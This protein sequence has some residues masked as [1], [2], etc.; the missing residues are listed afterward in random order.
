MKKILLSII[1]LSLTTIINAQCYESLN[2]GGAHT[3]GKTTNGFLWGWGYGLA[4]Q[5][6]TFNETEPNP[7]QEIGRA[8]V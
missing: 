8:H 6:L 7:I 2:F 3:I 5:L 4:G 1:F